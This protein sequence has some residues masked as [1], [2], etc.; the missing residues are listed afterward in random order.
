ME[1]ASFFVFSC[2][3][4]FTLFS[5]NKKD[6][7]D[8]ATASQKSTN[9]AAPKKRPFQLLKG[10]CINKSDNYKVISF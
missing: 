9:I 7:A 2:F 8:S 6:T 4:A 5:K 3:S 1:A 10:F